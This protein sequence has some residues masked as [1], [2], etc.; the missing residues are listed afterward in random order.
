MS[1]FKD[2]YKVNSNSRATDTSDNDDDRSTRKYR[3]EGIEENTD[4]EPM[5]E[6]GRYRLML[7]DIEERK[8]PKT[9]EWFVHA[10]FTV[11]E[12]DGKQATDEGTDVKVL[13]QTSGKSED[14]GLSRYQQMVRNLAGYGTKED[15]RAFDP[16]GLFLDAVLGNKNA[17]SSRG[18]V[19]GRF[20]NVVVT[21]GR[22]DNK[23]GWYREYQWSTVDEDDQSVEQPR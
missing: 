12:S 15:F 21:R 9:K 10:W 1:S 5:L 3:F 6:V 13:I 14:F 20:V 18:T 4:R 2:K 22:D 16:K 7:N 23:G 17:Y 19:L 8:S 11:V